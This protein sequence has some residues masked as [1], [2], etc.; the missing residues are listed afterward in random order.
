[1]TSVKNFFSEA[2]KQKITDAITDAERNTS[3]EIR[4]HIENECKQDV[5]ECAV[6]SF[7]KLE[8]HKT[9]LRNGV[10]F[11][12]SVKDHKYA[13][14]GDEGI[15]SIVPKDFW[16]KI[17]EH[18]LKNFKEHKFTEGLCEGIAMAGEQLKMHFPFNKDDV[19]ELP[20]EIS[21]SNKSGTVKESK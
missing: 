3:G 18:L 16:D 8:M 10:L 13:I 12:L 1:M 2:Q 17:K 20:N 4:V 19:N 5:L 7:E 11:Y 21:F 6:S 15:N 14:I 9:R